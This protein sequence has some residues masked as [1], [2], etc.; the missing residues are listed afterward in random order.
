MK[1]QAISFIY[2][3]SIIMQALFTLLFSTAAFVGIGYLL[4]L[5]GVG[6]WVYIPAILLGLG[7]GIWSMVKFI[8][9]AMTGLGRLERANEKRNRKG[10]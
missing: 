4:T 6:T 10:K 9:V 8:L 5:A 1:G 2:S 7:L 3:L